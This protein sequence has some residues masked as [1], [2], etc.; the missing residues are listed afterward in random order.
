MVRLDDAKMTLTDEARPGDVS[1]GLPDTTSYS[2]I[3]DQSMPGADLST[4][5]ASESLILPAQGD[6]SDLA[7]TCS[8]PKPGCLSQ[9]EHRLLFSPPATPKS[10]PK[11]ISPELN[12]Q[13][14]LTITEV[15]GVFFLLCTSV[16]TETTGIAVGT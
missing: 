6:P 8:D 2:A 7:K 14:K 15:S 9:V 13:F 10:K 16:L 12:V 4:V 1:L 3:I 5:T 11:E